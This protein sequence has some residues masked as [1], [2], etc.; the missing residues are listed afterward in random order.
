MSQDIQQMSQGIHQISYKRH[1]SNVSLPEIQEDKAQ[2]QIQIQ[3]VESVAHQRGMCVAF[4]SSNRQ[5]QNTHKYKYKNKTRT[6]AQIQIQIQST[7][8]NTIGEERTA[9]EGMCDAGHQM[10]PSSLPTDEKK[11]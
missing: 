9:S 6:K 5:E 1:S 4:K 2:I 3:L 7:N 8:T 10:S 11:N